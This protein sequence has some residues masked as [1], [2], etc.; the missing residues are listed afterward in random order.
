[1]ELIVSL[2][3][4]LAYNCGL[5]LSFLP[6]ETVTCTVAPEVSKWDVPLDDFLEQFLSE[7]QPGY[8]KVQRVTATAAIFRHVDTEDPEI[9]LL[10]SVRWPFLGG[11]KWEMTGG[12]ADRWP[13]DTILRAAEREAWEEA[14]VELESI[15]AYVGSYYFHRPRLLWT[16]HNMKVVFLGRAK[17]GDAGVEDIKLS[18]YEHQAFCWAK[19][20]QLKAMAVD[21]VEPVEV[22]MEGSEAKPDDADFPRMQYISREGK[23]LAIKSFQVLRELT[24]KKSN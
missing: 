7:A 9:L 5:R 24:A 4:A 16:A 2:A 15:D 14:A 22:R 10:Q 8:P 21:S 18:W 20:S 17:G 3:T 11:G 13:R 6:L 23:E 1:M 19:E 12:A